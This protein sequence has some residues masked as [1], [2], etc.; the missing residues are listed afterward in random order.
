MGTVDDLLRKTAAEVARR[1]RLPEATYRL[2]FHGGFTFQD[3]RRIVPYL[4]DL[5]ITHCYASPYLKA[6]PGSQH[7]YDIIDH[8]KLN[9]EIGSEEDYAA[10]IAALNA[11][12]LGQILDTVPN[13]MGIVGNENAWWNDVLE[14]GPASPYANHFDIAWY[15]SPR[16]E[17]QGRVLLPILG[18]PYGK[19]LE[20]QQ[21]RLEYDAGAF[22]ICYFEH[23][24]PVEPCSYGNILG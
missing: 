3:A 6:R 18:D 12:G 9:P 16:P 1:Q 5:G 15:A 23:R 7:G 24:W 11:H 2:Q 17:L 8:A 4:R 22:A 19:V 14:N 20:S 13:H 10:W 21:L